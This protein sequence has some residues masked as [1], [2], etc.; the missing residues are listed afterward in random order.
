M[1]RS[2]TSVRHKIYILI[3]T[4]VISSIAGAPLGGLVWGDE[5]LPL[6]LTNCQP[7][8]QHTQQ[9]QSTRDRKR[10]TPKL[11][12]G[13]KGCSPEC[14]SCQAWGGRHG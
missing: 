4:T 7:C 10:P 8:H 5:A 12:T 6:G 14:P 13:V 3:N 2:S 11:G 9:A 1:Y